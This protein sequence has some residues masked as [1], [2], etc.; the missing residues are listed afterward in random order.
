GTLAF[1]ASASMASRVA[2]SSNRGGDGDEIKPDISTLLGTGHFYFAL[3]TFY[4]SC[5]R[6]MIMSSSGKVEMSSWL[7]DSRPSK[8]GQDER[9]GHDEAPCS[10]SQAAASAP[11]GAGETADSSRSGG[12]LG[13][14]GS[15]GPAAG[16]AGATG[17]GAGGGGPAAG[18]A[19]APAGGGPGPRPRASRAL[20]P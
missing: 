11:P 15:A 20:P 17:G 12:A 9:R 4:R 7:V 6:K 19:R 2:R 5:D 3:T 18:A 1:S 14:D 13:A 16:A 8:G 10:G